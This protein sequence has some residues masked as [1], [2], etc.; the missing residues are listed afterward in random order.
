[1]IRYLLL[2]ITCAILASEA[3]AFGAPPV[4]C[5]VGGC[6]SQLCV[7]AAQGEVMSTCEWTS[8]Y[9]CYAKHSTCEM[10]PDGACGWTPTD[11]LK[12]CLAAPEKEFPLE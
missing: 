11:G 5:I 9:A 7:D 6:S 2:S 3:L 1:M 4:R 10:Q 12:Q 8:S